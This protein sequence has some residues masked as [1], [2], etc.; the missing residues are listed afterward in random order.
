MPDAIN[1]IYV[2]YDMYVCQYKK[3]YYDLR[4]AANQ[5]K[6]IDFRAKTEI[7]CYLIFLFSGFPLYI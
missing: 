6:T 1:V 5:V 2:M 4:N 7:L 3:K